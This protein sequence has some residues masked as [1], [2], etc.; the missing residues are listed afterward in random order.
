MA[1]LT[2]FSYEV[3]VQQTPAEP[4]MYVY[5][6]QHVLGRRQPNPYVRLALLEHYADQEVLTADQERF[7]DEQLETFMEQGQIYECFLRMPDRQLVRHHLYDRYV[8]EYRQ[9][10]SDSQVW[11]NYRMSTGDG[12]FRKVL[13]E[14]AIA[15]ICLWNIP[16]IGG[17]QLE[18][19]ICEKSDRME[20]ITESHVVELP[21]YAAVPKNSHA[22]LSQMVGSVQADEAAQ[23]Q[24]QM[25]E[26]QVY[27]SL[28]EKL[29]RVR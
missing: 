20:T 23:L 25:E 5:L 4:Q 26:Y 29:F 8:I 3:F 14:P 18:Y 21:H 22:R 7:V 9:S 16:M 6:E 1:Y 11:L 24:T 28:T 2:Y 19:Y 17:E 13:M 27:D 12:S 15:G 10:V